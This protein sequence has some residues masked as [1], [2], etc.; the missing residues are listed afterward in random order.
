ML[1]ANDFWTFLASEIRVTQPSRII[2]CSYG[3]Y[4]ALQ[5]WNGNGDISYLKMNPMQQVLYQM[6]QTKSTLIITPPDNEVRSRKKVMDEISCT[7]QRFKKIRFR[8]CLRNHAK[9]V[10]LAYGNKVR[11]WT[12]SCNFTSSKENKLTD[13]MTEVCKNEKQHF[14]K[15]LNYIKEASRG[16]LP[17]RPYAETAPD[18]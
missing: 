14:L 17:P 15:L 11:I 7:H 12:G 16:V 2:A 4:T 8:I 6:N 3:F 13:I 10:L 1:Y 18:I 9:I 5:N